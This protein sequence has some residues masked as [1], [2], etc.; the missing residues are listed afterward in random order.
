MKKHVHGNSQVYWNG[1]VLVIKPSGTFNMD[2][3]HDVAQKV[4]KC[5]ENRPSGNWLRFYVFEDEATLGPMDTLPLVAE[6]LKA[7]K[8][9]G[10][11]GVLATG[12]NSLNQKGLEL[13]CKQANL[14]LY[15][16]ESLELGI[17]S[18]YKMTA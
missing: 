14:P 18:A 13:I 10:C 16:C 11:V 17:A 6:S 12:G 1:S 3:V 2:G 5:I 15:F 7:S 9:I 8:S 4:K